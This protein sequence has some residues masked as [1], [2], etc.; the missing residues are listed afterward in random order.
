MDT[1]G[2]YSRP[3]AR[4]VNRSSTIWGTE[5]ERLDAIVNEKGEEYRFWYD[6]LGRLISERTFDNRETSFSYDAADRLIAYKNAARERLT[7]VFRPCGRMVERHLPNGDVDRLTYDASGTLLAAETKDSSVRFELDPLGQI[8]RV[9]QDDFVLENTFDADGNRVGLATSLG[10]RATFDLNSS[11]Q[12]ARLTLEG[13]ESFTF[14]FDSLGRE[15]SRLLPGNI[16]LDQAHDL[17]GRL[18]EQ[19]LYTELARS[20]AGQLHTRGRE[21]M[22]RSYRHAPDGQL[23]GMKDSLRGDYRYQY[24]PEHRLVETLLENRPV[25]Q[26]RYDA[27]GNIVSFAS[28]GVQGHAQYAVGNRLDE[29]GASRFSYD[30]Q[31]RLSRRIDRRPDGGEDVWEFSWDAVDQLRT[32]CRPDGDTWHYKYDFFGRRIAKSGRSGETRYV[33]DGDTIVHEVAPGR[34]ATTWVYEPRSFTPLATLVG[35]EVFAVVCDQL[36]VPR[37]LVS[38][39][40]TIVWSSGQ[41]SWGQHTNGKP[42]GITCPIRFPGQ[43]FDEETGLHYNRHRYYDPRIGRYISA[44][45]IGERGELNFYRYA[46]NPLNFIDPLG[47]NVCDNKKKGDDFEDA[48]GAQLGSPPAVEVFKQVTVD[49]PK[50]GGGTVRTRADFVVRD[51]STN[52]PTIRVIECKAS[53]TAPYTPNQTTAGFP[54]TAPATTGSIGGTVAGQNAAGLPTI[55]P[56]TPVTTVRPGQPIPGSSTPAPTT[57]DPTTRT[58]S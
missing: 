1:A 26:F 44:D 31:G 23:I 27:T 57:Y 4:Q 14:G 49:V 24:H 29:W 56:G 18:V 11:A 37:D 30:A 10:H 36:G 46:I 54:P 15:T 2:D 13:G 28:D 58:W 22:S 20:G 45:P 43:W 8:Q 50:P 35:K 19:V 53:P 16:R 7:F 39:R 12:L 21:L 32:V 42:A 9:S 55:P 17:R 5:P 25:E 52:P 3:R 41:S 48:V 33:W 51:N 40:G 6:A 34:D 38:R 47:L